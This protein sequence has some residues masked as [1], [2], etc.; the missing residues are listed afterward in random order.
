MKKRD[1]A[2]T[3]ANNLLDYHH[4][5]PNPSPTLG[6]KKERERERDRDDNKRE[7]RE[8]RKLSLTVDNNHRQSKTRSKESLALELPP[9]P[10]SLIPSPSHSPPNISSVE[11]S[12]TLSPTL[13]GSSPRFSSPRKDKEEHLPLV[14]SGGGCPVVHR[15]SSVSS[16]SMYLFLSIKFFFFFFFFCIFLMILHNYIATIHEQIL[17]LSFP[18]MVCRSPFGRVSPASPTLSID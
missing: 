1:K 14:K 16:D 12:P 2:N 3:S 4:T 18:L 15:R 17:Y 5:S 8:R 10:R 9:S 6:G 13:S 11:V 7:E